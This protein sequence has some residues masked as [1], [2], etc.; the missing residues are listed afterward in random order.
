MK[1]TIP[2]AS[3]LYE[4]DTYQQ[5]EMDTWQGSPFGFDVPSAEVKRLYP[6]EPLFIIRFVS[7]PGTVNTSHPFYSYTIHS[8]EYELW[9]GKEVGDSFE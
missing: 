5:V 6:Q 1:I 9:M 8:P 7:S 2:T 3:S 4:R